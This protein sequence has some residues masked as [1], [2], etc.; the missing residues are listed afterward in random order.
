MSTPPDPG[1]GQFVPPYQPGAGLPPQVSPSGQTAPPPQVSPPRQEE[2]PS[3]RSATVRRP[4]RQ[5][6][7][8]VA[9]PLMVVSL[10]LGLLL[11]VLAG[12]PLLGE[13][14]GAELPSSQVSPGTGGSAGGDLQDGSVAAIAANVLPSTVY[15]E[16]VNVAQGSTGS[17]FVLREDGYIVTN[18]HVIAPARG[19]G[20]EITVVFS[21]GS[22]EKAEIV[23]A[24]TD[25]DLAV[26]EV[27]RDD[28]QP[29]VLGG[30]DQLLVGEPVVAIGAPLGLEGTVTSGI[31]SALNRPVSIPGEES[32]TFINAIQTDAAINPG[33]SGGPLVNAAG[34]VIGVNSAIATTATAGQAG[35]VGLGFAIPSSQV[36]RT[37]QQLI[38]T[39]Q[40]TYPVIGALL[41]TTY[42]GEGVQVVTEEDA[43]DAAAISP[44]GPADQ[45]GLAPGDVIVAIDGDPVTTPDELIVR[46][47]ARAPGDVITLTVREDDQDTDLE[48]TLG[49]TESQ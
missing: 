5:I 36:R 20:G 35:S 27:D 13:R 24:S 41:N 29:L 11:G 40:A 31:V 26:L 9:V 2:P 18:Q 39:G 21:D 14:S 19:G 23:G 38:E 42:R 8:A 48:V 49:E 4:R 28:L 45:A 15:I 3:Y 46:I 16:V 25:Y 44:D 34:E 6:L 37:T 12:P 47:R 30:S 17:G 7:L 32:A 1:H 22:E 43:T 10:L 33:N